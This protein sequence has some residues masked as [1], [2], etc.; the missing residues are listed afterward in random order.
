VKKTEADH[1]DVAKILAVTEKV[2][3]A[4]W[5]DSMANIALIE[6]VLQGAKASGELPMFVIYDLPN[7][8]CHANASNGEILCEDSSCTQGLNTY[9]TQYVDKVIEVFKKYPDV[10]IVAIVEPDSLPNLA[11]NMST[12]KCGEA[13]NAYKQGVAYTLKQ[14]YALGNVTSYLDAAHGGWLGWDNN[15]TAVAPIFREVLNAAGG[16]ETIR[17]FSTNVANYQALGSMSSNADPCNLK[18]Q[19]NFAIDEA[20]YINLFDNK[21]ASSGLTG[22][23][24]ITDTSRNGVTTM[25]NDCANWCNIKNSGLGRRP[26]TEV[27]DLGLSNVDALVWVKTPGESDGT[28]DSSSPRYDSTCTS[29]D[30]FVP[31][32]E[33]GQWSEDFYVMLAKNANPPLTSTWG[34]EP[35]MM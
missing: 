20:H 13:E 23:H 25:R 30:A 31:S 24:Y 28:S 6:P 11:T 7:R 29:Q 21:M 18:S 26:T 2:G 10:P 5:I 4:T 22:M 17:G 3:A 34:P 33:A 12:P 19:Y 32:P 9:K 1:P 8:D 16:K 15:L 14:L 27:S 35:A